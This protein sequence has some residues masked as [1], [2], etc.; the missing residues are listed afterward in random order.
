MYFDDYIKAKAK[1]ECLV[2]PKGFEERSDKIIE[3][4]NSHLIATKKIYIF[5]STRFRVPAIALLI[6]AMLTCSAFAAVYTL[7]GGDFFKNFF[8]N[9]ANDNKKMMITA[10]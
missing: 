7:S 10:I 6:F 1:S 8:T 3:E 9:K 2:L 4:L 5:P